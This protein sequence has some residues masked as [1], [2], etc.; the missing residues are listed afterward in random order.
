MPGAA[1]AAVNIDDGYL[2]S[3]LRLTGLEMAIVTNGRVWL[4]HAECAAR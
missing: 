2:N 4:L 3:A 1:V